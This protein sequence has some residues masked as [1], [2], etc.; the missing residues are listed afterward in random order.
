MV[1]TIKA[2]PRAILDFAAYHLDLGAHRIY[3]YLDA[4]NPARE[5]LGAHP[6]LRVTECDDRWWRRRGGR[7]NKHQVRQS[8]NATHAYA[9][10]A[11]VDWLAHIDVDEFLAPGASVAAALAALPPGTLTARMRP[12]EALAGSEGMFKAFIPPGPE[13]RPTVARLYPNFGTFVTGGFLSHVAGKVFLRTGL[14]G[15]AFRI[16]NAFQGD[17]MNPGEAEAGEA[18]ALCH[19]HAGDWEAWIAAFQ[20]R[21]DRGAYRAELPPAAK[22]GATLHALLDRIA[23]SEGE[24]GL[25]AFFDEVAAA[26]PELVTRLR[27]EGL[28]REIDLNLQA[29]RE[30]HF[31]GAVIDP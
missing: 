27:R 24:A 13:R 19:R 14:D 10:R 25:R 17:V 7:P 21:L 2:S 20:Y 4:P 22:N 23:R 5:V 16:H 18:L 6:K 1:A 8:V 11:E 28:L 31:P 30:K 9:R 26:S 12:M 3:L 15:I 29:R